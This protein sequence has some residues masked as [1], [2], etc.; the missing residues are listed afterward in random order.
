ML[1]YS[2]VKIYD[3]GYVK[4]DFGGKR[5]VAVPRCFKMPSPQGRLLRA[6][7]VASCLCGPK[8]VN[9]QKM[10]VVRYVGCRFFSYL[11]RTAV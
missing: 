5:R 3:V 9:I 1:Q 8:P 7:F 11:S 4:F 10:P 6:P 2:R